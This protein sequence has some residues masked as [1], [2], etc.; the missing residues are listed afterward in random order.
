M[1]LEIS[2]DSIPCK[3]KGLIKLN[4]YKNLVSSNIAIA[5]GGMQKIIIIKVEG[6][7]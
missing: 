3:Q 5:S 7:Y 2:S 1:V 6:K 4:I